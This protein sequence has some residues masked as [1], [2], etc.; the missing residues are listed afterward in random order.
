MLV[1]C[2]RKYYCRERQNGVMWEG[3]SMFRA[4]LALQR[5]RYD[6]VSGI[7]AGN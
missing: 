7:V 3:K 6:L 1:A 5:E 2:E 4:N